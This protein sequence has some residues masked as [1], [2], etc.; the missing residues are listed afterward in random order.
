MVCL[1]FSSFNET[2]FPPLVDSVH[3]CYQL[4]N[5]C[6]FRQALPSIDGFQLTSYITQ[7]NKRW[8]VILISS[9]FQVKYPRQSH[10]KSQQLIAEF[11]EV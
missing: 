6:R 1:T 8:T 4:T 3:I 11:R 5:W 7:Q 2:S 10:Q 9:L